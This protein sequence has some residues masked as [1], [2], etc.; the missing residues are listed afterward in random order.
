MLRPS[1]SMAPAV[2][3]SAARMSL[4][5]VVLP[6]P[7]SPTRPSVSPALMVKLMPSTAFTQPRTL[8][9]RRLAT[10]KCFLRSRT[11]SNGSLTR[12]LFACQPAPGSSPVPYGLFTW[13]LV[14]APV[15]GMLAAGMEATAGGQVRQIRRLAGDTVER[16]LRAELRYGV[17]QRPG[18]RVPGMIKEAPH[19]LHLDDLTGIHHRHLVAHLGDNTQVVRDED[20]GD[21]ARTL[22]VLQ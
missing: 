2:G 20:E 21:T 3:S 19:R 10:G 14:T 15:A 17:E 6:Q 18:V 7:D 5:V 9:N 12:K 8:P 16:L 4:E 22:E 1:N 13:F 11:S